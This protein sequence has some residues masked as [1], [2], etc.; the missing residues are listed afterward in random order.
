MKLAEFIDELMPPGSTR[1]AE[2]DARS[3]YINMGCE[4]S[5]II[6]P[7]S[8]PGISQDSGIS[9]AKVRLLAEGCPE[10]LTEE[11]ILAIAREVFKR[12]EEK[13][14]RIE[15]QIATTNAKMG[16]GKQVGIRGSRAEDLARRLRIVNR[17]HANLRENMPLGSWAERGRSGT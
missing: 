1:R 2:H 10:E 14:R 7:R 11:E 9:Q 16:K 8:I 17:S 13:K 5:S 12:L 3:E 4:L 15:R 6:H